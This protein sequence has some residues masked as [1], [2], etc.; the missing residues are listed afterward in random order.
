MNRYS[1][2]TGNTAGIQTGRPE[3]LGATWD[4]FGV[5][6]AV[7]SES[8]EGIELCLFAKGVPDTE[9]G[10]IPL[11]SG[12]GNIW[13]AYVPGLKPGQL[14][15]YRARGIYN[16]SRGLRFNPNKLLLDPYAKAVD[17]EIAL[18]EIHYDWRQPSKGSELEADTR[19]SA[20]Y[21]PKSVVIEES[22]GWGTDAP[23]GVPWRKTII[24][25]LHVKGFTALHPH[26]PEEHRG[27]YTGL[28]APH[29]LDYLRSLGVT[30]LELMPVHHSVSEKRLLESGLC[31]YWGYNSIGYFAPDARFS[32]TGTRG[33]QVTEFKN[34]IKTLHREGFEVILDVVYNHTAEGG[35]TGP[36][37][38]LRGLDNASYYRLDRKNKALYQNY[39]GCG[40]TINSAK[41]AVWRLIAD[42]LR[43]WVTEMHVDGFRF[44]LATALFRD[45]PDYDRSHALFAIINRD[46]VLSGV[47]LIAEPWDLGPGGYQ[48][49]SYP[50]PWSEWNDR[51]RNTV[52]RFWRVERGQLGDLAYRISGSSDLYGTRSRGPYASVNYITS[53]DGFTLNDLVTYE[54]KHNQANLEN[55]TDGTDSNYSYNFGVEGPTDDPAIKNNRERQ[56]RNFIATLLL[57]QGVPMITAG[58]E[59]GRTQRGNNNAYCQDNEISWVDWTR[60]GAQIELLDFARL[61]IDFRKNHPIL[62]QGKF[63]H[64]NIVKHNGF[65]DLIWFRSDGSEMTNGDWQNANLL[66]LGLIKSGDDLR[67]IRRRQKPRFE[68]TLM[69]LLNADP[70][71]VEFVIPSYGIAGKWEIIIDTASSGGSN[72]SGKIRAGEKYRT[73]GKSLAVLEPV[74][75]TN[76][77]VNGIF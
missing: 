63:F 25:E 26:V 62:N 48:A 28:T 16:P 8:A 3:P 42:S 36:T 55:G 45:D 70:G 12:A 22:F 2:E 7:F 67:N 14:Y 10:R 35:A 9:T 32:S 52:R 5:N 51:Y 61:M 20:A 47:K 39:T 66:S 49:G 44:D 57:S 19:D 38:S 71:E 73:L 60:D 58:D 33:Q 6:F 74:Y 68:N 15:G 46:P 64:G 4:G 13:R 34:M 75:S 59:Y 30:T 56:K 24:Y 72:G 41:P 69:I 53:H 40:N 43:Y 18:S 1:L 77:R 37:L 65:K 76:T 54:K 31:N 29:V 27:T 11:A 23:P 17:G 50:E 21:M